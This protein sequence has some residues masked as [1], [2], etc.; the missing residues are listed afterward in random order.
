A[1]QVPQ[2]LTRKRIIEA[3]E[4]AGWRVS[5][6]RGAARVLGLKATTLESRMKRLGITRPRPSAHSQRS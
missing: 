1:D 2:E 5:G 4:Q 3:L 6:P